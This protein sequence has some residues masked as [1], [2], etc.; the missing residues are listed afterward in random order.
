MQKVVIGS[1]HAGYEMK[2][3]IKIELGSEYDFVDVGTNNGDSVDYPV[4]A[5]KVARQVAVSPD[6]K[7]IVVCGSGIGV[8]IAANKVNGVRAALCYN[9]KSA[10]L[11]RL[12]NNANV[13]ATAGREETVDDPVEIART[14]L[15]TP[16]SGEP[17][18]A[19]R[20]QQMMDIEKRN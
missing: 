8:S 9:K 7:G 3:R 15:S 1:D 18:H 2:E 13:L 11:S 20:V 6:V 16:F 14:F 19:K 4:Y 17:R 10:E 5:E 12:H